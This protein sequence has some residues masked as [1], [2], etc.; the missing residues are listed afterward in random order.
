MANLDAFVD[1]LARWVL[2]EANTIDGK[3][4]ARIWFVFDGFSA[5]ALRPDTAKFL[6]ALARLC[7]TG[8][9]ASRHRVVF[10]Q[11]DHTLSSALQLRVA[12]YHTTP[13][14]RDDI[15][16]VIRTQAELQDDLSATDIDGVV[17]AL[18]DS[19]IGNANEPFE[20]L[21]EIGTAL[22]DVLTGAQ[23]YG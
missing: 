4:E 16:D 22:I 12:K 3:P 11:L 21:T 17:D 15:R 1:D 9:N 6:T 23:S 19:V 18:A 5:S 13:L 2:S 8:I 7:T 14:T 10:C 20:N